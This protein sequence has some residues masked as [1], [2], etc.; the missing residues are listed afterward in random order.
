MTST[1]LKNEING[2]HYLVFSNNKGN[3][4]PFFNPIL[5]YA[6]F[7]RGK[8]SKYITKESNDGDGL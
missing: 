1:K 4:P 8:H 6:T 5:G 2:E 7:N 3:P